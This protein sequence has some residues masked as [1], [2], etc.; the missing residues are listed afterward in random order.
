MNPASFSRPARLSLRIVVLALAVLSLFGLT[1]FLC[2]ALIYRLGATHGAVPLGTLCGLIIWLFVFAFHFR[3][4]RAILLYSDREVF[5]AQLRGELSELGYETGGSAQGP[6]VYRPGFL[7]LL[8]GGAVRVDLAEGSATLTGPKLC[9]ERVRKRLRLNNHVRKA[10][11][12][13]LTIR[14]IRPD[15]KTLAKEAE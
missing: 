14:R 9:L 4:E 2:A 3:R 7:A 8:A 1:A 15:L 6:S 13:S 12:S 10:R 5:L 11:D